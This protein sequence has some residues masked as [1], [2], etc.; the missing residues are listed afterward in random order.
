MPSVKI[1]RK[2]TDTD[3]TP[4]VDVAF[5]ILSFFIMATKFK[6]QEPVPITTPGSVL[7][8]TLPESNAVM[9][10]FDSAN[11]VFFTVLSEKEPAIIDAVI[12]N[13]NS[14]RSL[15]LTPQEMSNFRNIY[16][17]GVPFSGL[18]SILGMPAEQAKK[19]HQPGI[20]VADSANNELVWWISAAKDA[21]AGKP[22]K[23]LIKGDAQSLYPTFGAVI[24][25][26]KRNEE[27]KYNLVTA[28][29]DVPKGSEYEKSLN[30]KSK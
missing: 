28:L 26:L 23:F 1:P 3:M 27:F 6:P 30:Q 25:A 17:I 12:Q 18:K 2:S 22:L 14:S 19:V 9:I 10:S 15:N 7:T 20:P 16:G 13:L 29:E 11:R 8:Q 21:F 4:F 5:L 24:D